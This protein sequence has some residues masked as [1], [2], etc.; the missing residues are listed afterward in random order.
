M[1]HPDSKVHS[2][3]WITL[4]SLTLAE[5]LRFVR[6]FAGKRWLHLQAWLARFVRQH[7]A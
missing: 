7:E 1:V 4:S 3:G 2:F 6:C 5:P